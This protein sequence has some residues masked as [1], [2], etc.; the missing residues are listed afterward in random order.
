MHVGIFLGDHTPESGGGHTLNVEI[1]ESLVRL[2]GESRHQFSV[3]CNAV[4]LEKYKRLLNGTPIAVIAYSS[5]GLIERGLIM[6]RRYLPLFRR[7][8]GPSAVE[9]TIRKAGV[10]FL[11]FISAGTYP[12]DLPY[13]TV[14]WDLQHRLQPYFPEVSAAGEWDM[15]EQ[16]YQWFLQ[17]ASTIIVGTRVGKAEIERFYQVPSDRI[18]VLP[19]PTPRFALSAST[20]QLDGVPEKYG[21][22]GSN[23]LFY[24]AQF[25]PHK[26]HANLLLALQQL[27]D[28]YEVDSHLVLVGSDKGNLSY[29]RKMTVELGLSSQVHFLGFVD[30][31]ELV[32][33]YRHAF[34][35]VN[36]T[37][38]GP[39]NLPPLEAFALGCPV[40]ASKVAGAEEQLEDAALLVDPKNP[41]EIA[42]AIYTL[43][44]DTQLREML[45]QR[46]RVRA[47][48]WTGHDF[49]RGVFSILDEF[50]PVRRCWER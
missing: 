31:G 4:H 26:N 19:L 3:V 15:R 24:P 5:S 38:F 10:E 21:I 14:V 17:R 48:K 28:R 9:R 40:V 45:L 32:W 42:R 30:Q 43:R 25:W 27:R 11:W 49:V 22:P 46:G 1:F 16:S 39:D 13:L 34:A 8:A 7:W 29:I 23:Y 2:H 47:S 37:F 50:E 44:Q 12:V 35:L 6:L 33:L 20:S 41:E 18:Q 36:M